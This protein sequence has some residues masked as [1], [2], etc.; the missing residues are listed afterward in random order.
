V[1]LALKLLDCLWPLKEP[2]RLIGIRFNSI[3]T[4]RWGGHEPESTAPSLEF[5]RERMNASNRKTFDFYRNKR[6]E[7]S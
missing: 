6:S 2:I 1:G 7:K 5:E 4:K 3:R